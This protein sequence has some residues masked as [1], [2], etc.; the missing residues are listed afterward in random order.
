MVAGTTHLLIAKKFDPDTGLELTPQVTALDLNALKEARQNA[1]KQVEEID[2][3]IADIE[4][5]E[6]E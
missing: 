1:M 4:G 6:K 5:L 3:I 2:L